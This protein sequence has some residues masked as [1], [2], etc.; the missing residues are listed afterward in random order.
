M[1]TD[2]ATNIRTTCTS[3]RHVQTVIGEQI[4]D[5]SWSNKKIWNKNTKKNEKL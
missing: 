5:Q 1:L 4:V 3:M 2:S